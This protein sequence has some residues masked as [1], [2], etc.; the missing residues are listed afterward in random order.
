[1]FQ[2]VKERKMFGR[3]EGFVEVVPVHT[4]WWR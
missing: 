3:T 4:G 2:F 1:M